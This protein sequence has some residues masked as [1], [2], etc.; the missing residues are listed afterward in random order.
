MTVHSCS[1]LLILAFSAT[2]SARAA[3]ATVATQSPD[4]NV[5]IDLRLKDGQP[6][7]SVAYRGSP[8]IEDGLMGVQIA[9]DN[10]SGVYELAGTETASC[11]STWKAVWGDLSEVPDRYNELTVK[12][13][14]AAGSRRVFFVVL[15]AY[16][17]GVGLRYH[18]PAQPNLRQVA[19]KKR[20]TEHRFKANHVIY[21][22]RNYEYGTAR[23]DS[24][25]RSEGAV[26]VD[27][28]NGSF[29]A[30]TDADRSNF[31]VVFWHGS[32][33]R[34]CTI[35]GR[36][37]SD[38][39]GDLPFSTSWEVIILGQSAAKLYE[40]RYLVENLNSPCAIAATSWI[41]PGKAICQVRNARLVTSELKK[42]ADFASVHRIDYLEIDHSW[43]GA[44]TKWTAQQIEFFEKHKPKFW[45]DKPEWRKNVGGNL[46]APAVGWVPFRPKA[47][48]GGNFVDLNLQELVAY[49]NRLKPKVGICV[50]VRGEVLKEFG[51]EHAIEDVFATYEKWGLAGVKIGFVPCS[52]QRNE[53]TVAYLVRKAAEHKLIAVI[54][55][56]YL[57]SGLSRTYPNLVNVEGLA[58]EEAEHS[59]AP[60]M[61][62]RHDVMLPFTRG[63]MGPFDYT[64]EIYKKSK[65]FCH[66]VAMLGVYLGRVSIR[67]GVRQ[68]SPTGVGGPEIEF[69]DKLPGLFEEKRVFTRLGQYVTVARRRGDTWFI[70]SMSDGSRRSYS[71]PLD[72]LRPGMNYRASIYCDAAD[73]PQVMHAVQ[74]VSARSLIE[75]DMQ[76]NGGHLMII[77]PAGYQPP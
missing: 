53:R 77:E 74:T 54:H 60:D 21:Q 67:G 14:E 59:I 17:E 57:P 68:W 3:A 72:F 24:M 76:A 49:A 15:R 55:D 45:D 63:L 36:L 23:I 20:L 4:G 19:I 32:K 13:A 37:H 26:T 51:G 64:P 5:K 22:C 11:N 47:N 1:I 43:C 69:V 8:V 61:K 29:A 16:N 31:P 18:L 28:G 71:L 12:L 56:A 48:S 7:W 42:V 25:S 33:D 2:T 30:L 44:E 66:Q 9:P 46:L 73:G 39:V 27:L 38:A 65:T 34:P 6:R 52:S 50:Y 40:N 62:S 70:A 35:V 75:I 41:R 10:L 58:G